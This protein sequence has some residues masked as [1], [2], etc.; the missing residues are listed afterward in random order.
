MQTLSSLVGSS[1]RSTGDNCLISVPRRR[2]KRS[3]LTGDGERRY[4]GYCLI[5]VYEDYVRATV[6]V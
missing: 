2:E 5:G 4:S 3:F 6:T 1:L